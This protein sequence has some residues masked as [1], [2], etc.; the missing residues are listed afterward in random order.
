[1]KS[2]YILLLVVLMVAAT[3]LFTISNVLAEEKIE[4]TIW[5]WDFRATTDIE[6]QI[7]QFEQEH[8]GVKIKGVNMSYPDVYNKFLMAAMSGTGG[9]DIVFMGTPDETST[10]L[11]K[12]GEK[13]LY[14]FDE[15]LPEFKKRYLES[16]LKDFTY[17]G[18]IWGAPAEPGDSVFMFYRK[19]IFDEAGVEFPSNWQEF[20]EVGKKITTENRYM[21]IVGAD[22]A[23]SRQV[24]NLI[25]SR[26][27][28]LTDEQGNPDLN[29][30]KMREIIQYMA[31]GVN[32]YKVF[33]FAPMWEPSAW[34][35]IKKGKWAAICHPFWYQTFALKDQAYSPEL[36]G[37]WRIAPVLPWGPDDPPTGAEDYWSY[38]WFVSSNSKHPEL[39]AEFAVF[40]TSKEALV[41][42]AKRRGFFPGNL[43]ALEEL[44]DY[45]DPFFG[46]QQIYKIG[47][48]SLKRAPEFKKTAH[49][50]LLA[51]E[52]QTAL[53]N[54][55]KTGMPVDKALAEAEKRIRLGMK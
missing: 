24:M 9:P 49:S 27:G 3:V 22:N 43:Q 38:G 1:M 29:N 5:G 50:W 2:K 51:T 23:G 48:E 18:H 6:P 10:K 35:K 46:G 45:K 17:N 39:A 41:D 47:Y 31:D 7:R 53:V 8:P 15:Y 16:T 28:R 44:K 19:D 12:L 33:D 4:L 42:I 52:V 11:M 30:P 37:K 54:V 34:E 21:S 36:V 40:L 20:L 26:G 14:C 32:K 55:I 13:A 25:W